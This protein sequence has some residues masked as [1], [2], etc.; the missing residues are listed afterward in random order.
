M[1][2][3]LHNERDFSLQK[4][5]W[6]AWYILEKI[7]YF[8]NIYYVKLNV[9]ENTDKSNICS[10]YCLKRIAFIPEWVLAECP[11]H[12]F[13]GNGHSVCFLRN[14]KWVHFDFFC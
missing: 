8:S 4:P 13:L 7:I 3:F 6:L 2:Q 5:C 11:V 1:I 9:F 10:P 12:V 14:S